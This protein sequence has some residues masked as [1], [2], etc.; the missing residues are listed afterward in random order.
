MLVQE[1]A[2]KLISLICLGI[3]LTGTSLNKPLERTHAMFSS[4]ISDISFEP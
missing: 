4:A 3:S 2:P 1:C